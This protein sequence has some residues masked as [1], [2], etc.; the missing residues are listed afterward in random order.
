MKKNA[1]ALV[2][3]FLTAIAA[4]GADGGYVPAPVKDAPVIDGR[5]DEKAWTDAAWEGGF[6]LLKSQSFSGSAPVADTRFAL[7]KDEEN[8]YI[9]VRCLEPNLPDLADGATENDPAPWGG[10]TVEL[11]FSPKAALDEFYQF[12]VGPGGA[13][14]QRLARLTQKGEIPSP[15]YAPLY[16]A[17]V[18]REKDAWT[19]EMRLPLSAFQMTR[20]QSFRPDWLFNV[21]RNRSQNGEL[22]SWA[23][24]QGAFNE[25][26]SFRTLVGAPAK[27][28]E[29]DVF[30]R[31]ARFTAAGENPDNAS[32]GA[33]SVEIEI[34]PAAAGSYTLDIAA[35]GHAAAAAVPISLSGGINTVS[36][37]VPEFRPEG[38]TPFIPVTLTLKNAN[39]RTAGSRVYPVNVKG[40]S[41]AA[42]ADV[43]P[44]A[45][46]LLRDAA[47]R[48]IS[49][50]E[51]W[52][53]RRPEILGKMLREVYGYAPPPPESMSFVRHPD[54]EAL[55]GLARGRRIDIVLGQGG[56]ELV[57]RLVLTLPKSL[58]R[59]APTFLFLNNRHP[60]NIDPLGPGANSGNAR[61][62]EF[63]SAEA[64]VLRGYGMAAFQL[65]DADP[66]YHD[67][68]R[69]GVHGLMG[70]PRDGASWATLAGWAWGASR[71]LDYL[72]TD[73]DVDG[74]RVAVVGHSRGGKTALLAAATDPRFALAVSNNS[75]A[76]G[77]AFAH[78]A[79]G[80]TIE[81]GNTSSPHWYAANYRKYNHL[82][83]ELDFD[84]HF[85]VACIA[86]RAVYCGSAN[87]D[88]WADPE[89]EFITMT[90]A[91]PVYRLYGLGGIGAKLPALDQPRFARGM[92]YHIRSG[93]HGL[94]GRDWEKFFDFADR[95]WEKP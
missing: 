50:V 75:G 82:D 35:A 90:H 2:F 88:F 5:L 37:P 63:W 55:G 26:A 87:D 9:A 6:T 40:E 42:P 3:P 23:P 92:G 36:V 72:R 56:R 77:M 22:S 66:D 19:V 44:P 54:F 74:D 53:K 31:S 85:L 12:A 7:L 39:G 52:E 28:A 4:A 89:G 61:P 29:E 49:T 51:G 60:A 70:G 25:T 84:Q 83:A 10:D 43:L 18:G 62:S 78:R 45:Y 33:L 13:K 91:E 15:P 21:A 27:K 67:G 94:A 32:G 24:L 65:S 81:L 34:D 17:K 8:L 38:R 58:D 93:G 71:C 86:P 64:G 80:E 16:E 1:M 79:R 11:F 69:N 20:T 76:G 46:D 48:P 59:P 95:L 57:L 47:G 14:T 73:A 68:F 41:A 30:I